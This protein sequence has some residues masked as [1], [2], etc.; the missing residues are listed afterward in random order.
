M[1]LVLRK[2]GDISKTKAQGLIFPIVPKVMP[3]SK[4]ATFS[5][6]E[7]VIASHFA[8]II[9][10]KITKTQ[11]FSQRSSQGNTDQDR[12]ESWHLSARLGF[13][14]LALIIYAVGQ[15]LTPMSRI[16]FAFLPWEK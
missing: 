11:G 10:L 1:S 16:Y 5:V 9:L 14:L 15:M 3:P 6:S 12:R 7:S 2:A 8:K 13:W 4:L